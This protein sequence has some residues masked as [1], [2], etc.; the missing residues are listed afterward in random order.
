MN[1]H[2]KAQKEAP[3]REPPVGR[4]GKFYGT[5]LQNTALDTT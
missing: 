2:T 3:A 4:S 1:V 5:H